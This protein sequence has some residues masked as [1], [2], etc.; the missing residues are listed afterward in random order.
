MKILIIAMAIAL[1]IIPQ[2]MAADLITDP[3][4]GVATYDVDV[5]G[6][7]VEGVV[8]ESD[9]SLKFSVDSLSAG[10]HS[11]RVKPIG[12]GGWPADWSAPFD[13]TKPPAASG[14]KIVP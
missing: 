7:V 9:G 13:A 11:F 2:A 14:I 3:M 12:Q 1:I 6:T 10:N 4:A 5:D 8:A